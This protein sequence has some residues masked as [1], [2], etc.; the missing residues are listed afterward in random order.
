MRCWRLAIAAV[1]V[2]AL[3]GFGVDFATEIHPLLASRC[4][5]C[6]VWNQDLI[7]TVRTKGVL[8]AKVK[9][10]LGT[11]MP[12]TGPALEARQVELL[13][14]WVKEGMP[15]VDTSARKAPSWVAPLEP[16]LPAIPAAK[17]PAASPIDNFVQAYFAAN[18]LA[19]RAP[20][21]DATFARRVY[22]DLWGMTPTPE[23]LQAF[24][25]DRRPEKRAAL[26]DALLANRQLFTGHWIS[27]WNDL[28]RNDLRQ[29]HGESKNFTPWLTKAI[30]NNMA[31]DEMVRQLVRPVG[32]EA[33]EG[34]L[35]GV[36]WR[37][38]VSASQLPHMQAA[39][40]TAQVFLGINLKCASCHD[41]FI[42][43]YRL[44]QS[45]GLAAMFSAEPVLD[46]YRCDAKTGDTQ[47]PEFL[48]PELGQVGEGLSL[49]E[50]RQRA[51]ELF[52]HPKNGRLARTFVNRIWGRLFG[53]AIVEPVDDMDAKPFS[54]DLLDWLA[55][56]FAQHNYDINHLLRQILLSRSFQMQAVPAPKELSKAQFQGP[57][58][59]RLTAEQF[60]DSLSAMTGEWRVQ[61]SERDSR[62][63]R[64]WQLRSTAL[65]RALGRP[66]RDQVFTTRNPESTTLQ[67]MELVNGQD[68][69]KLLRRGAQ[70]LQGR[71]P[72]APVSL[73]DS[74]VQRRPGVKEVTIPLGGSQEVWLLL[75]DWGSYDP[76]RAK[77]GWAELVAEGP[78]GR[79]VLAEV[80]TISGFRKETLT[81]AGQ[82]VEN[83]MVPEF[84]KAVVFHLG[85]GY[86][87]VTGKM[88]LDDAGSSSDVNANVRFFAFPKQ[89]DRNI[90][91]PMK[92]A[93]PVVT[94]TGKAA[95]SGKVGEPGKVGE[96]LPRLF[97]Q[98]LGRPAT[99]KELQLARQAELE[100]VLWILANHPEFQYVN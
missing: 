2:T 93:P 55:Y 52:T 76:S 48:Y 44:R 85:P 75:E 40:N 42:N 29:Y 67:A 46:I 10:E 6:H 38:D 53:Q 58:Q 59:R 91:T 78:K 24:L 37:G 96:Q 5:G 89:P 97:L 21:S 100:D 27:F 87:R 18:Q 35:L 82:A 74:L 45:Y 34:F 57:L 36:N 61:V 92:E 8:L 14:A 23:Q 62:F 16:R 4:T 64:E 60:V 80:P 39:Q 90:L 71:L 79:L 63:V 94:A 41:S 28:L 86:E 32:P 69:H 19:W 30:Q 3:P 99:A 43:Q 84:G 11:R 83:V 12:P 70:R 25:A 22:L 81:V 68:L 17:L 1:L 72:E 26:V 31:Y 66:I 7:A 13:A 47:K 98:A 73:F 88:V 9:G 49:A 54:P 50:R 20:V 65:S 33:P 51:A 95:G 77:A 56:D 15:Y